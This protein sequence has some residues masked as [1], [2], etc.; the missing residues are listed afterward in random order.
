MH[1]ESAV[2]AEAAVSSGEKR[3]NAISQNA[4]IRTTTIEN[5]CLFCFIAATSR[6]KM[7]MN[8]KYAKR[9]PDIDAEAEKSLH[10]RHQ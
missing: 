5:I 3:E 7:M 2:L 6:I 4:K 10:R 9:P 1:K 8:H